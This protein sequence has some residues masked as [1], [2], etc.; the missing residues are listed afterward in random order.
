MSFNRCSTD[1]D[2]ILKLV[3]F[4]II[5]FKELLNIKI[6]I[7]LKNA[8]SLDHYFASLILISAI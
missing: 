4:F 1:K 6:I 5:I 7:A 8:L 2:Y 3:G